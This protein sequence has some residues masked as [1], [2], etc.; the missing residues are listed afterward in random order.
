M[1]DFLKNQIDL[2]SNQLNQRTIKSNSR[3][4]LKSIRTFD[5]GN[6][7][8]KSEIKKNVALNF[9]LFLDSLALS[10]LHSKIHDESSELEKIIFLAERMC[11]S[12]GVM[13]SQ[14]KSGQTL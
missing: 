4:E 11:Q 13:K 9:D 7:K 5:S 1:A 12:Q 6:T 10:S 2:D 3:L 8:V 14:I